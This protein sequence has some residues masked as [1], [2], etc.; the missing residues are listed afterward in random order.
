M[1]NFNNVSLLEYSHSP[2]FFGD[3][4]FAYSI[5]KSIKVNGFIDAF[6]NTSGVGATFSGIDALIAYSKTGCDDIYIDGIYIGSGYI[7]N[8]VVDNGNFVMGGK[9]SADIYCVGSGNLYNMTGA[10]FADMGNFTG[11]PY[12]YLS[13]SFSEQFSLTRESD[14]MYSLDHSIG[15][16]IDPAW[17]KTTA[18]FMAKTIASGILGSQVPQSLFPNTYLFSGKKTYN[19]S[20]DLVN[21][22]YSF[23]EKS[24]RR[25][26]SGLA[27]FL[28]SYSIAY[29]QD[30]TCEVTEDAQINGLNDSR[31]ENALLK[32][33]EIKSGAQQRCES[34]RLSYN[35][36]KTLNSFYSSQGATVNRF[37][38]QISLNTTFSDNP[39]MSG[40]YDYEISFA[41]NEDTNQIVTSASLTVNGYGKPGSSTKINNALSGYNALKPS[42]DTQISSVYANFLP[43]SSRCDKSALPLNLLSEEYAVEQ[44]NGSI[45]YTRNMTDRNIINNPDGILYQNRSESVEYPQPIYS[46]YTIGTN[47][48]RQ[49]HDQ[50]TQRKTT[51]SKNRKYG[52]NFILNAFPEDMVEEGG[53]IVIDKTIT[54]DPVNNEATYSVT[55]IV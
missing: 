17:S 5:E 32:I 19:E 9:F 49:V 37:N 27:D 12:L 25:S 39:F 38:G 16:N 2:K 23:A 36:G 44:Y 10:M 3:D 54:I 24:A 1:I 50:Q 6:T 29:N 43:S 35:I 40:L 33:N 13:D 51:I 4:A 28:F 18:S 48:M 52:K 11:N 26:I 46:D 47:L 8:I 20:Y 22:R 14:G 42:L 55:H 30:G 7:K 21:G 31:Y 53:D 41:A 34:T 45:S 15:F